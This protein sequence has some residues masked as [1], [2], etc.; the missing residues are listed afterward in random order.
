[1]L[2]RQGDVAIEGVEVH[3]MLGDAIAV[4]VNKHHNIDPSRRFPSVCF[5]DGDSRQNESTE[6]CV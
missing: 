1:M 2:R 4:E 6:E 3:A 5:V